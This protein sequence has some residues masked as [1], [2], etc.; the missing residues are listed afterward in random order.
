MRYQPEV[1]SWPPLANRNREPA[2]KATA[3]SSSAS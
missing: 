3:M 1:A 2:K